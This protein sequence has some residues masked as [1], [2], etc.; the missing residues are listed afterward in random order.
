MAAKEKKRADNI[1]TWNERWDETRKGGSGKLRPG[2]S[3][4]RFL[5]AKQKRQG[6]LDDH[7][8]LPFLFG[9][10]QLQMSAGPTINNRRVPGQPSSKAIHV[11][12]IVDELE[13]DYMYFACIKYIN[14][15]TLLKARSFYQLTSCVKKPP[16]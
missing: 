16:M 9:S 14:S 8:F 6:G 3:A 7:H 5:R 13:K 1:A 15:V 10:A 4:S 11:P 2:L 12:D